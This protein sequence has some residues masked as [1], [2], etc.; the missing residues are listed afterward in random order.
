MKN[1]NEKKS[2][3]KLIKIY[4]EEYYFYQIEDLNVGIGL[5][6]DIYNKYILNQIDYDMLLKLNSYDINFLNGYE[7]Y[8][9]KDGVLITCIKDYKEQRIK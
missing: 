9:A 2:K 6:K 4:K 1:S 5:K 3:L 8:L 7:Y